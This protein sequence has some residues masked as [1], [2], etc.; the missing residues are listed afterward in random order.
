MGASALFRF[1]S[2]RAM[3]MLG[4]PTLFLLAAEK[5]GIR[6][7]SEPIWGECAAAFSVH[8]PRRTKLGGA[9]PHPGVFP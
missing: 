8:R 2:F 3:P 1:V 4:V 6:F 5:W 7:D 9:G